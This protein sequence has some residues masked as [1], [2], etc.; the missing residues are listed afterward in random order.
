MANPEQAQ[1]KPVLKPGVES[2]IPVQNAS[3]EVYDR[4]EPK[5]KNMI[6]LVS[7]VLLVIVVVLASLYLF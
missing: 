7:L 4:P 5:G 6:L 3:D 2:N 1:D